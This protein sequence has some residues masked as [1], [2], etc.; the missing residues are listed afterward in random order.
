MSILREADGF[1]LDL[2]LEAYFCRI[3]VPRR[4]A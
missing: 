2:V 4:Y 3:C 1:L